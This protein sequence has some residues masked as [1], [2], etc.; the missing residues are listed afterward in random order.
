MDS[1]LRSLLLR[2]GLDDKEAE[3][4]LA[5]LTLGAARATDIAKLS[6]QSRSHTYLMLRSLKARGLVSE[7]E[8]G[9]VLSFVAAPPEQLLQYLEDRQA[10][11]ATLSTLAKGALPQLKSLTRPK[12]D[13]PRV[14]LLHGL[15]GMK[16]IYREIFPNEFVAMFN[17][18]AMY[19]AFGKSVTKIAMPKG[20]SS[21]R[22]RDLLVDNAG[23]R[24]FIKE[25]PQN[26]GYEAR[27][28]PKGVNFGTDT[29]VFND[30][31]VIFAYDIDFTIIRIQNQ[32]IADSF[33]AWFE[34]LWKASQKAA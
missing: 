34:V 9:K 3:V 11:L 18:E 5:L 6:K 12:I 7:V 14:T 21:L 15:D 19:A 2:I 29:M 22:G 13:V 33:R 16:Q 23:A 27:L 25:N 4:Y 30:V 10:E 20:Q 26:D 17:P 24:N 8:R 32:N 31:S 1:A 28:L